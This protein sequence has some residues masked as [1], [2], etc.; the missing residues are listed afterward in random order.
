MRGPIAAA[1]AAGLLAVGC[2][3][4]IPTR[5]AGFASTPS[6]VEPP[7]RDA[8]IDRARAP[9]IHLPLDPARSL[10]TRAL[11]GMEALPA[12]AV[13][14]LTFRGAPIEAA[15]DRLLA[16][17]GI[18]VVIADEAV[19]TRTVTVYELSG[20]LAEV[21]QRLC[22]A[23]AVH[24]RLD[25][26]AVEVKQRGIYT[27]ALP[28]MPTLRGADTGSGSSALG[29]ASRAR[30]TDA[31]GGVEKV[32]KAVLSAGGGA[33]TVT[34][35]RAGGFLVFLAS[36]EE[37]RWV[38]Q[39]FTLLREGRPLILYDVWMGE[40]TL[41]AGTDKGINWRRL[42]A[43]YG[44]VTM[45]LTGGAQPVANAIGF[46]LLFNGE[47]LTVDGLITFLR[48]EGTVSTISQPQIAIASGSVGEFEAGEE[49]Y[50]IRQIGVLSYGQ[51]L[52][53]SLPTTG[54]V[55]NT[56]QTEKL[57]TGIR[58]AIGAQYY[59]GVVWTDLEMVVRDL[60]EIQQ[61]QASGTVVQLPRLTRRRLSNFTPVRPGDVLLIGGLRTNREEGGRSGVPQPFG[62]GMLIPFQRT[63][64]ARNAEIIAMIRPRVIVFS[65]DAATYPPPEY[66]PVP[67]GTPMPLAPPPAPATAPVAPVTAT[68]LP[69]PPSPPPS[70]APRPVTVEPITI[71]PPPA[72]AAGAAPA[73]P[74][75]SPPPAEAPGTPPPAPE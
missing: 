74:A 14:P 53:P 46:D 68:P 22:Q 58:L 65:S 56:V 60:L 59:E 73:A 10:R 61:V 6:A 37:A 23:A 13:G 55:Q 63:V 69:P 19:A 51:Q 18:G 47:R 2:G 40:V 34:H 30:E 12:K 50:F 67:G 45:G 43:T 75:G 3:A 16:P 54:T 4:D 15:L 32:L 7:P 11:T 49:V 20:S 29:G 26:G 33:D 36:A 66:P 72:P 57:E 27:V 9:V 21:A 70:A 71:E 35:D 28:P 48:D 62:E 24:C 31:T 42:A 17:H 52:D 1:L 38:D 44:G 25:H 8:G 41:N 5:E 39:Y 64:N